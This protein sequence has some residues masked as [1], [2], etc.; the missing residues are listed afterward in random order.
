M[1][2]TSRSQKIRVFELPG[3]F[4]LRV[5]WSTISHPRLVRFRRTDS[6]SPAARLRRARLDGIASVDLESVL[7]FLTAEAEIIEAPALPALLSAHSD[8]DKFLASASSVGVAVIASGDKDLLAHDGWRGVRELRPR[9]FAGEFLSTPAS[10]KIR[11]WPEH[12][13]L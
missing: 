8:D 10:A 9:Q 3:V 12:R 5:I 13:L 7:A 11:E 1:A 2:A 4:G 6:R